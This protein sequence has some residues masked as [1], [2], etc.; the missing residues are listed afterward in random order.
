MHGLQFLFQ[1]TTQFVIVGNPLHMT[2]A[3][4]R[5][6]IIQ[7]NN[8]HPLGVSEARAFLL[9]GRRGIHQGRVDRGEEKIRAVT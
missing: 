6:Y 1:Y 3:P 5:P 8:I 9:E 4:S 2:M 7:N